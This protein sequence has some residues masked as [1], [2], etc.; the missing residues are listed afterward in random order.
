[1][2]KSERTYWGQVADAAHSWVERNTPTVL[3][4][5]ARLA[6]FDRPIGTWLLLLP[7]WWSIALA[8]GTVGGGMVS[9]W[10]LALF[11]IGALAMRGA[12]CTL[13]DIADQ[14]FDAKVARTRSRPIPSGQV[15][16]KQ[17]W[18]FLVLQCLVGLVVLL[19][20]NLFAIGV[21]VASL[22]IVAIYPFMKRITYYPQFV[23]GLAFNWGAL[24]GWAVVRGD[25]QWPAFILYGAGISWTMAYD[26]IY[27]HQDKEDDVLIGVKSTALK[28]GDTTPRWLTGFFSLSFAL[29]VMCGVMTGAGAF[30]FGGLALAGMHAIWQLKT[31]DI[32]DPV[33]CL[34]LF[35]SNR[36][37]GLIIFAGMALDAFFKA[38]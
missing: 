3:W 6:R 21:G 13:N 26:T 4:P 36:N 10:L 33:R 35:R 11:A 28:F 25:L 17:A 5:Y 23:L 34:S 22:T 1:M 20:F 30:Y 15:S 27:A 14:D 16:V 31:L 12:G 8:T 29:L 37:L 2:M 9:L 7:C 18:I 24:L 32:N 38:A 19:Q